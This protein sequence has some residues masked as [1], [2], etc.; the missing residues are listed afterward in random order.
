MA[1]ELKLFGLALAGIIISC[2]LFVVFGQFT[3]R[4]LR[5]N[6]ATK[7]RLGVEFAS[8]WDIF[9]VA[10][11][12]ALPKRI[13]QKLA[14]SPISGLYADR[15]ILEENTTSFD[16]AL[17]KVFWYLQIVSIAIMVA[18]AIANALDVFK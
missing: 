12:L 13:T 10:Q 18:L 2:L 9:N 15:E 3:V 17:A 8:G 1:L 6:P 16:R 14:Q 5:K 11:A 7:N 4:K